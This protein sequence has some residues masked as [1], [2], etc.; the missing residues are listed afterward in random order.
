MADR[1]RTAGKNVSVLLIPNLASGV[2]QVLLRKEP[3]SFD[4]LIKTPL[5]LLAG[6][7]TASVCAASS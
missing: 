5:L 7:K 4:L 1:S 2:L 6:T 3:V